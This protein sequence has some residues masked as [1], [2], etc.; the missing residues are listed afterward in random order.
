M[1]LFILRILLIIFGKYFVTIATFPRIWKE[2]INIEEVEK[3]YLKTKKWEQIMWV[4][5]DNQSEKTV[6]YFHGNW[7]SLNIFEYDLKYFSDMGYN[8]IAYDFPWYWE[9]EGFPYEKDVYE[10]TDLF[11]NYL[12]KEKSIKSENII[13]VGYSIGTAAAVDFANKYTIDKLIIMAPLTSRHEMAKYYVWLNVLKISFNKDSFVSKNK[14]SN[15]KNPTLIIH[16]KKDAVIPNYMWNKLFGLSVSQNKIMVNIKDLGHNG[17][18]YYK[19]DKLK[20]IIDEFLSWNKME[21]NIE[22]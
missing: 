12:L 17:I 11:Y 5:I 8:V 10:C 6:Y 22:L 18:L 2:Q 20:P 14:I 3:I 15:I 16:G 7:G 9:S 13:S 19:W 4:Y 21:E 1:V